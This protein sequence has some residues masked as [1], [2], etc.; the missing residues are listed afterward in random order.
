MAARKRRGSLTVGEEP[1]DTGQLVLRAQEGDRNAY[2]ELFARVTDR[3]LLFVEIRLG[4]GL[5]SKL[6][7][8]DVLQ[9]TY[10]AAYRSF[11]RFESRSEG[12]FCRWLYWIVD[13]RIRDL[14]D[15]FGSQKRRADLKRTDSKLLERLRATNTGPSTACVRREDH[16]FLS[17]AI[18]KLEEDE[19]QVLLLR[20]F[21]EQTFAEIASALGCSERSA[22][23]LYRRSLAKIGSLFEAMTGRVRG[24]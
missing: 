23:R 3:L 7:P 22:G 1:A 16:S 9:E 12:A 13:N 24:V 6:D 20:F 2:D 19:R 8:M 10:F 5:R 11:D 4:K 17:E 15:H 18:A 21:Q 14:A